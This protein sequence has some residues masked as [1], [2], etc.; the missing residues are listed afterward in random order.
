M[1]KI[2]YLIEKYKEAKEWSRKQ[3]GGTRRQSIFYNEIDTIL[4]C[5]DIVTLRNVSEAGTSGSSSP[6]NISHSSSADSPAGSDDLDAQPDKNE[7]SQ[8]EPK[9]KDARDA[10][11]DRKKQSRKRNRAAVKEGDEEERRELRESM[12]AFKKC[13]ENLSNF[14]ETSETQKQQMAMMGQFIGARTQFM[15]RREPLEILEL[16]GLTESP[17]IKL[18]SLED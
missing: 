2:K 15:N 18:D 16:A 6:L 10:R 5:R 11:T 13:G 14:M 17:I 8:R 9:K 4:G 1:M 3:T 7:Q 12:D